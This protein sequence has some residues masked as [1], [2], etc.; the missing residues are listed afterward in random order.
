MRDWLISRQ[1]YWGTPI[2]IFYCEKCGVVPVKEEDLPVLLPDD[3]IF[4]PTGESP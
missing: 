2:P 4:R 1:R 3:A